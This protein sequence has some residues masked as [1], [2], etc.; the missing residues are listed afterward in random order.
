MSKLLKLYD[1]AHDQHGQTDEEFKL[2]KAI[3]KREQERMNLQIC[4]SKD[5][6]IFFRKLKHRIDVTVICTVCGCE[7]KKSKGKSYSHNYGGI[8][9]HKFVC[10][11]ECKEFVYS[12]I[13]D[14]M[15]ESCAKLF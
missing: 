3:F 10:S 5:G 4:K 9:Q 8:P 11:T 2:S 7:Y 12:F 14:R 13:G 1:R 15:S 6:S